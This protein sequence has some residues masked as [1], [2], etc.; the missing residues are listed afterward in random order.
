M[1][2]GLWLPCLLA[3][4][5]VLAA[6]SW[7][8]VGDLVVDIGHEIAIPARL[9][10]GERLYADVQSYYGP[11][12]YYVNALALTWFGQRLEVFFAVGSLLALTATGLV[13]QLVSRLSDRRWA[14]LCGV[15]VLIDCAFRTDLSQF[16]L[17]YS[18][19]AVYG[20]VFCLVALAA[21]D[22]Y[23]QQLQWEWLAVAAT[24]G[25]GA[26]L[27]KQEFGA[28]ALAAALV[29]VALVAGGWK[30][31]LLRLV[32]VLVL[33]T[34][35][36]AAG[37]GCLAATG[38]SWGEM[39]A[40]LLPLAKVSQFA[41]NT[42]FQVSP[43]K[44][45]GMW[46]D[47]GKVFLA[48]FAVVI[49]SVALVSRLFP[50]KARWLVLPAEVGSAVIALVLLQKLVDSSDAV[51]QPLAYLQWLPPALVLWF[52]VHCK[53]VLAH[54][55]GALLAALLACT[56]VLNARWLF[57]IGFFGLYA[58]TAIVLFFVCLHW[59]SGR[60]RDLI[61]R[62]LAVC[63]VV[64]GTLL[65]GE[66]AEERHPVTSRVGTLYTRN[67]AGAEAFA[68]AVQIV[69]KAG[70]RSLLVLPEGQVLNFMTATRTPSRPTVFLPG[71]LP[72]PEAE[73]QFIAEVESRPP[74]L[75]AYV[76][77][78]FGE[79]GYEKFADFNPV[80]DTWITHKHRLVHT[81]GTDLR[82]SLYGP[83]NHQ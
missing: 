61:A 16:V 7:G 2:E 36:V 71:V 47:T 49:A 44:S 62:A 39:A 65:L 38:V 55:R 8:R 72:T 43:L 29:G 63:L 76:D 60:Y 15:C 51:F 79:W 68:C 83:R 67:A 53:A 10:A 70:A 82:I 27:S 54:R 58:T 17:P 32:A 26:A 56:L 5:F 50:I 81:C 73:R 35:G 9:A 30:D 13:F 20:T 22:A 25:A 23:A 59:S 3:V 78:D 1:D 12:P 69:Q 64:A 18:Y 6:V 46:L 41:T 80:V 52:L 42:Y 66:H 28:A 48:A 33:W 14:A 57:Y 24:A 11:L 21:V 37:F 75:I 4:F 77:R 31:R 74:D 45:L 40:S 34:G 19:G